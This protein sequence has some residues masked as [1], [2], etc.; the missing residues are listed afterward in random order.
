MPLT[1][2]MNK[3][4]LR[5]NCRSNPIHL[6]ISFL[7]SSLGCST[8]R[9]FSIASNLAR[10]GVGGCALF[11][12]CLHRWIDF[13]G[14]FSHCHSQCSPKEIRFTIRTNKRTPANLQLNKVPEPETSDQINKYWKREGNAIG[15]TREFQLLNK[16]KIYISTTSMRCMPSNG[17]WELYLPEILVSHAHS[18][19][20]RGKRQT[21][22]N[23]NRTEKKTRETKWNELKCTE[24]R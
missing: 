12:H 20:E 3:S 24:L 14:D 9:C 2:W 18:P 13:R 11:V 19:T 22:R 4:N 5:Q 21:R 1:F 16:Y 10:I 17:N 8:T 7:G 15:T 6:F 23:P